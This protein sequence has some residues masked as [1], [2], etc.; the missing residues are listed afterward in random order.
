M[1]GTCWWQRIIIQMKSS[2][3][4]EIVDVSYTTFS[5]RIN[6]NLISSM[7]FKSNTCC[8]MSTMLLQSEAM[9]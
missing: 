1:Y 3:Y 5:K 7:K 6:K 8:C 4:T 2:I 9:D